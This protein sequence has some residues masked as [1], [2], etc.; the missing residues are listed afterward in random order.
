MEAEAEASSKAL[1]VELSQY[2][3]D[4]GAKKPKNLS[5]KG[6]YLMN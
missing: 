6:K 4:L 3:E 5:K 1:L 2:C